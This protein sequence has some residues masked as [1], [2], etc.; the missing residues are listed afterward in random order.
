MDALPKNLDEEDALALQIG[1]MLDEHK[2]GNVTVLDL[3]ALSMWTDFFI[4]ATVTS[5]AHLAGLKRRTKDFAREHQ[6]DILNSRRKGARDDEWDLIDLGSL[7]VHLMTE[8]ARGFYEL[9]H[10]W[11]DGKITR[12]G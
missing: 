12:I 8:K 6:L 10:L 3:R 11:S 1:A 4:I 5:G 9:E 2:G 7:V